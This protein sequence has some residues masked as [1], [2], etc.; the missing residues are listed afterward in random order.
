MI[1]HPK[2]NSKFLPFLILEM[3]SQFIRTVMYFGDLN[4]RLP[5]DSVDLVNGMSGQ[6]E[7]LRK[8][9]DIGIHTQ[10]GLLQHRLSVIT[11]RIAR[12]RLVLSK[13]R[14]LQLSVRSLYNYILR[15]K[16]THTK[17]C[18]QSTY[19]FLHN[20]ILRFIIKMLSYYTENKNRK[21]NYLRTQA[22]GVCMISPPSL[23]DIQ[24]SPPETPYKKNRLTKYN[25]D[26]FYLCHR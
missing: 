2:D 3:T 11:D 8:I 1:T 9:T 16:S 25:P 18:H 4:T 13:Y 7:I 12:F 24:T 17:N 22:S 26:F 23:I 20:I 15:C 6:F 5:V 10:R 19:K 21:Y 14:Q